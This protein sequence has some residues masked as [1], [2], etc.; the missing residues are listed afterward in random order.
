MCRLDPS[1][2]FFCNITLSLC[3][4]KV[5]HYY[6]HRQLLLLANGAAEGM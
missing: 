1:F 6:L 2:V 4:V 3:F 5:I